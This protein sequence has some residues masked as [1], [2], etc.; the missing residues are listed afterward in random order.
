MFLKSRLSPCKLKN[1][2]LWNRWHRA[3]AYYIF[4]LK[5]CSPIIAHTWGMHMCFITKWHRQLLAWHNTAFLVILVDPCGITLTTLLSVRK[6]FQFLVQMLYCKCTLNVINSKC[7]VDMYVIITTATLCVYF[8][9]VSRGITDRIH[10]FS[11]FC[12]S[13]LLSMCFGKKCSYLFQW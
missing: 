1:A 7:H 3:H 13:L 2:H 5:A 10:L 4:S 8:R 6:S 12:S 9:N 11:L